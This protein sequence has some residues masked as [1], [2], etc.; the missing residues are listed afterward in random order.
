[1]TVAGSTPRFSPREGVILLKWKNC[2]TLLFLF[3]GAPQHRHPVVADAHQLSPFRLFQ[4]FFRQLLPRRA[5][6]FLV[7]VGVAPPPPIC[8]VLKKV[9]E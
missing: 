4:S 5:T 9:S 8:P 1:M 7:A 2:F 3:Q 6:R